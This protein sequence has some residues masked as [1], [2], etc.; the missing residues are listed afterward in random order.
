MFF[1]SYLSSDV[2]TLQLVR[3]SASASKIFR[4]Q[5]CG[6]KSFNWEVSLFIIPYRAKPRQTSMTKFLGADE[7]IDR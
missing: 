1:T 3:F 6:N 4:S 7:K 2:T 5:K